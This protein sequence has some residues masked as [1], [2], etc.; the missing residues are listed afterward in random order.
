MEKSVA[1]QKL[2]LGDANRV[3]RIVKAAGRNPALADLLAR[4]ATGAVSHH[5]FKRLLIR[6]GLPVYIWEKVRQLVF[7]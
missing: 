7:G 1:F 3:D 2:L 4:Y 6:R 5:Q